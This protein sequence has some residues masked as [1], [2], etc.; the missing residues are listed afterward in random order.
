MLADQE[1]VGVVCGKVQGPW[2]YPV[3]PRDLWELVTSAPTDEHWVM[4]FLSQGIVSHTSSSKC[5]DSQASAECWNI[6]SSSKCNEYRGWR[7]RKW[8]SARV[9]PYSGELPNRTDC[10]KSG[11][12][13]LLK[14]DRLHRGLWT[15]ISPSTTWSQR[16]GSQRRS[17]MPNPYAVTLRLFTLILSWTYHMA[18]QRKITWQVRLQQNE[19]KRQKPNCHYIKHQE[20]WKFLVS[21]MVNTDITHRNKSCLGFCVTG[22]WDLKAQVLPNLI[23]LRILILHTKYMYRLQICKCYK[24][25]IYWW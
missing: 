3:L 24:Y 19:Q 10:S 25:D 15:P 8:T 4:H 20:L 22:S 1:R 17:A 7:V 11:S 6:F 23:Y 14:E 9:W 18:S 16:C 12:K 21:N 2:I 5:D 13:D